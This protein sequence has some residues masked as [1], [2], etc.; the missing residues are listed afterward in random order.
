MRL[1]PMN[2]G[3]ARMPLAQA[4]VVLVAAALIAG[5]GSSYRP[6]VT[7]ITGS[8]PTAQPTSYVAV[9]SSPSSST[10]GV[11]TIIDYSGDTVMATAST[12]G[13]GPYAFV[14][15]YSGTTGYTIN[16]DGTMTNFPISTTL[17]DK[18]VT[19]TTLSASSKPVNLLAPASGLW[20]ADLYENVVDVFS[21]S[22]EALKLSVPVATTPVTV[23]GAA[24][25]SGQRQYA[26]SQ[27]IAN[28]T[29]VE[30]NL[31]PTS[32]SIP[33]G[34]ATPIEISGYSYDANI[35]LGKCPVY[36]VQTPDL[37]RLFVLNRGD[38][39][40][41]VIDTAKN[42]LDSCTPFTNQN[43]QTVTCHPS[44]PLSTTAGLAQDANNDVPAIAGPVYA[45]YNA[46]TSQLVVANYDGGTI[47]VIDVSLD[48]YYEDS[49][50][51]GT[52]FTIPV[53]TNPASVAVLY[54]GSY[55]YT[56][57]QA[58][59]GTGNGTVSVVNLSSHEVEKTLSVVGHPRHVASTQNGGYSKVYVASPDSPY[60]TIV[61]T[62]PTSANIVDTT[63]KMTGN[64]VDLRT[65][66]QNGISYNYNYSSRVPGYGQPCNLPPSLEPSP[67][68]S[69]T[70][71]QVC[72]LMP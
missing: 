71:L 45:E 60:V 24:T 39:T 59:D 70:L 52:T 4:G 22:P 66:T 33:N 25:T 21:G 44:L 5:C 62:T 40:V 17:Q 41:T 46:A 14:M 69:Q 54:D 2:L 27:N 6:V 36:A 56:A 63:L 51:F 32:S 47:T 16:S 50:N 30:C 61:S 68:G 10:A 49:A 13:I 64:V 8:G 35:T 1:F 29:G 31:T 65:S 15:D 20:A 26:I 48:E 12:Q 34:L 53:G 58:D 57:N 42:T 55:A 38:D 11:A 28:P 3:Q 67:T 19:Y 72:Q 23:A 43:G 7:P 37:K 9:V 18:N